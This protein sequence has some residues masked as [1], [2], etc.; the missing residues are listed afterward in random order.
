MALIFRLAD[1]VAATLPQGQGWV[2]LVGVE[3]GGRAYH[4]LAPVDLELAQGLGPAALA[5]QAQALGGRPGWHY[6]LCR[7]YPPPPP[8]SGRPPAAAF[9][10]ARQA[11]AL[12]TGGELLA[13][14]G[15]RGWWASL[16]Q[17][18]P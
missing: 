16:E 7:G 1:L 14:A 12:A 15:R 18:Q 6:R 10:A 9:R 8:R 11:Q 2:G 3:P 4:V 5:G 17:N 13:W